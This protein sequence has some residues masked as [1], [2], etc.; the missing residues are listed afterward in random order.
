MVH[1][2]TQLDIQKAK[3]YMAPYTLAETFLP[4]TFMF[5]LT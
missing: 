2:R 4:T 1:Q 3:E 5:L